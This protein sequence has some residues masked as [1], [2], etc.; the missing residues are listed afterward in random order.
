MHLSFEQLLTPAFY[1]VAH[2]KWESRV[3]YLYVTEGNRDDYV[4]NV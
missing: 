4:A 3:V 1:F 2:W